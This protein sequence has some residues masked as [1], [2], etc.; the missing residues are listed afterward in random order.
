MNKDLSE[1]QLGNML[2]ALGIAHQRGSELLVPHKRHRPLPSAYRNYYQVQFSEEW[3][4]VIELGMAG[5]GNA[6]GQHY[7]HVTKEGIAHL[8]SLGYLFKEEKE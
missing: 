5:E 7:Y 3:E 2:H 4:D 8:K 6:I 1:E